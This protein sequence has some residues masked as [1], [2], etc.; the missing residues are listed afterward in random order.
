MHFAE[1]C[2]VFVPEFLGKVCMV[3]S[4]SPLSQLCLL[5]V[6]VLAVFPLLKCA[7]YFSVGFLFCSSALNLLKSVVL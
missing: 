3:L 6:V 1:V 4:F 7:S 5:V 2:S